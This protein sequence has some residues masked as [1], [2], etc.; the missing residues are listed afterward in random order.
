MAKHRLAN[1]LHDAHMPA[2]SDAFYIPDRSG[3]LFGWA[4]ATLSATDAAKL[5]TGGLYIDTSSGA[6]TLGKAAH[7]GTMLGSGTSAAPYTMTGASKSAL[8]F[9]VTTADTADSNRTAYLRLYLTGAAAGGEAVRA[10]A[11]G[12]GVGLT[13]LRGIHASASISGDGT[14]TGEMHAI[15]GTLHVPSSTL[16]GTT[17]GIVAELYADGASSAASNIAFF[18]GV[19]SGT[20]DKLLTAPAMALDG[21]TIGTAATGNTVDAISGDKAVTHLMLITLNGAPYYIMLRNAA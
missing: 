10:F 16:G 19:R 2:S 12:S 15:K 17:G 9:Y 21:I 3:R 13:A 18:R 8:S 1:D 11:T 6:T 4:H 7:G 5:A 20:A 14:I